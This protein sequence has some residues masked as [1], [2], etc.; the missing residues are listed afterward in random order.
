[1]NK[2]ERII[3]AGFGGQGVMM[4]GQLLAY[5]ANE[6]GYHCLWHPAY[7]PETR[8]GT[9]NCSVIISPKPINSPVFS[10]ADT[11]IAMN[12]PSL[13]KFISKLS[14]DGILIYNS[15]LIE[16]EESEQYYPVLANDLARELS[17]PKV[18]NMIILGAYL[19]L[20]PLFT[21]PE[22]HSV[23]KE[24]LGESKA[25]LLEI[26]IKAINLGY[27]LFEGVK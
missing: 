8:G 4:L 12:R 17:N 10:K 23:L 15:S 1:M 26:D 11:L 20:K 22:I 3:I 7:G 25:N 14:E 2:A 6:K 13:D 19:S 5:A 24:F 21:L 18:A 16:L 27:R 9:A